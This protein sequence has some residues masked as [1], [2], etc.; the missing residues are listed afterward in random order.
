MSHEPL[1][2]L[3]CE[4][5]RP[6]PSEGGWLKWSLALIVIGA[7]TLDALWLIPA[8]RTAERERRQATAQRMRDLRAWQCPADAAPRPAPPPPPA[9]RATRV[10]DILLLAPSR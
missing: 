10:N 5:R 1:P 7:S 8:Q 9:R 2:P 6:K 4:S 3:R